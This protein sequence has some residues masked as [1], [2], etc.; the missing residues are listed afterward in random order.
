LEVGK[1][2]LGTALGDWAADSGLG[3][4]AAAHRDL[5]N[6]ENIGSVVLLP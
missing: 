6:R 3:Y 1:V 5:E 4:A 2:T